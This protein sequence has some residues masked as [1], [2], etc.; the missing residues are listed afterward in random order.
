MQIMG[1]A[2]SAIE[3][4]TKR[5]EGSA[6]RVASLG[7]EPKDGEKPVDIVEEAVVRM[8]ASAVT[9]ANLAVIKSEDERMKSVLD[10]IA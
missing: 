6:S 3:Y 4:Q 1:I 5:L 8:D 2:A 9:K 7:K 10:I